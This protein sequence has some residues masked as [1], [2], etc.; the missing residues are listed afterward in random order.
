MSGRN[1]QV[2]RIRDAAEADM[3]AVTGI[4]NS[5]VLT[6]GATMDQETRTINDSIKQFKALSGREAVL[7]L[8]KDGLVCG[9]GQIKAY[10]PRAGYRFTCETAV[11]LDPA[12][13]GRG[14]GTTLK[15]ALLERCR[16]LN[17][18]HVVNKILAD[19]H[20]SVNYNL[21]LGFEVVG[22]QREVGFVNGAWVDVLI[23]Q[24]ILENPEP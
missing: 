16:Q 8:E 6:G 11:Y 20:A 2:M 17:Y 4:Y 9:W 12:V 24:L 3:A 1:S 15:K 13:L 7:V 19:N 21:Q 18:H 22:R 23:M 5:W 14:L 10:S